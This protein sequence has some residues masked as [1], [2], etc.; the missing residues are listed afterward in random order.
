MSSPVTWRF[1][2][3]IVVFIINLILDEDSSPDSS[4]SSS[5]SS[6][7][8]ASPPA[9]LLLYIS[10]I[11]L[12]VAMVMWAGKSQRGTSDDSGS[13]QV[14]LD[15]LAAEYKNKFDLQLA[16]ISSQASVAELEAKLKDQKI[17]NDE[18]VRRF[19]STRAQLPT[20]PQSPTRA[21]TPSSRPS[22]SRRV[23]SECIKT[24]HY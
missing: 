4:S 17:R 24:E 22:L 5:S 7:V 9:W 16:L 23:T 14:L 18:L 2:A 19:T 3:N 21:P 12:L 1:V 15:A 10:T 13:P 11:T 6:S 8:P 20:P